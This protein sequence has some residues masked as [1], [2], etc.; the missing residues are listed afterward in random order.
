MSEFYTNVR[1]FR[2]AIYVRGYRNGKRFQEKVKYGPTLFVRSNKPE[3]F[4]TIH[5]DPVKK[6]E[7]LDINDAKEFIKNYDGVE[8]FPIY[9]MDKWEYQYIADEYPREIMWDKEHVVTANIDIEVDSSNGFPKPE[10]ASETVTAITVKFNDEVFVFGTK[11][12]TIPEEERNFRYI[13]YDDEYSMLRGFLLRWKEYDPDIVT[14]W[15]VK[16]FDIPYLVNRISN[17]M[18]ES[19]VKELSPWGMVHER[20]EFDKKTGAELKV[21]DL[22]GVSTIDYL[23]TYKKFTYVERDNYKLDTIAEVELGENKL[24]YEEYETLHGLYENDFNKFIEY[25]VKDVL[26]VDRLETKLNLI[27]L[28]LTLAYQAKI[29]F[30]DP[31]YQVRMWDALIYNRLMEN[32]V[33]IPQ[34][35]TSIK[36]EKYP[37]A[38]VKEPVPAMYEWILSFDLNSLYPHLIM[39]Y[40]ISPETF[41]EPHNAPPEIRSF[42]SKVNVDRLLDGSI[43]TSALADHNLTLTAN[44]QVWKKDTKG[45]LPQMMEEL[46]AKRKKYKKMMLQC[47]QELQN[48]TDPEKK[49]ELEKKISTYDLMQLGLKVTLN[50]AYGALGNEFF[51]FFDV[52]HA[53]AITLSGQ[54]SI[55]WVER[56][57][58]EW[59][60][61]VLKTEGVD[62]V[63]YI[64][65]DS[66]YLWLGEFVKEYFKDKENVTT[67]RIV[68]FLDNLGEK[69]LQPLID[70]SYQKLADYINAY[71]QKMIMKREVIASKGFWR[72]KKM[73]VLNVHN[74]EG[75]QYK[76]PKIKVMGLEI[77]RSST[78]E[79]CRNKLKEGVKILLN[80]SESDLQEFI[81]QTR[82]EFFELTPEEIGMPR[83]VKELAKYQQGD[84][85]KKGCPIGPKAAI[86]YN[87]QLKKHGLDKRFE[88]VKQ[89]DKIKILYL[90]HPNP[91]FEKVV[92]FPVTLP[93]EF[94]LDQYIDYSVQF[95]KSFLVPMQSM[96]TIA[97][98]GTEKRANLKSF[99]K[100]SKS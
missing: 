42:L 43:D 64:D 28:V 18:G 52:R 85:Y 77:V 86:V 84:G 90:K 65:T 99:I 5:G 63:P 49:K 21:Y 61:K 72:G 46:Y 41:V 23:P 10:F 1:A 100:R 31:F 57:L 15:N 76:E 95:E 7:F 33:V 35:K 8:N 93:R 98:W 24:S 34:R 40:N 27:Q 69:V 2:N 38:Y 74:S 51:R 47:E 32:N 81:K 13:K 44:G 36:S 29:N 89:G 9:G 82:K 66:N 22:V 75:V 80:E 94:N 97:G 67:E 56:A 53:S 25:N 62:Y 78:P 37:G 30:D 68:K 3:D 45:F 14:G 59:T 60:N 92:G 11:E 54:L 39:Q 88:T 87:T 71:D 26:L 16:G 48:T 12:L 4:Q 96:A 20:K 6:M 79:F 73:Y 55:R 17:I 70:E 91:F 83:G 50:S 58:N 19:F